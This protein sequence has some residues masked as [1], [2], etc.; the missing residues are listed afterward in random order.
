MN[1]QHSYIERQLDTLKATSKPPKDELN[2][3]K[4]LESIIQAEEKEL[5]KLSKCSSKLKARVSHII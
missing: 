2:R 4:E 1:A 3:L 5:E